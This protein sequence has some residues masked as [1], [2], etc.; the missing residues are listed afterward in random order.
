MH[1]ALGREAVE[2]WVEG[3][4]RAWR[5]PGTGALAELFSG[6]AAYRMSPYQE[7]ARGLEEIARLWE[8][9]REGPG[10][11]FSLDH[12]VVAVDGGTAVV[13]VEVVYG[14][15][16]EYRDLWILRF[17]DDGRCREFEEWPFWPGQKII[18]KREEES[19]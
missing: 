7:P 5:A 2:A 17:A 4:E 1:A 10:E 15:G 3:Y 6:D 19:G 9:E 13:R 18:A 12:E 14:N 16:L 8:S 11:E